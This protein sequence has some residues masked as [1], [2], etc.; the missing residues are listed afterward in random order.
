MGIDYIRAL[1][2]SMLPLSVNAIVA[3]IIVIVG[4][5]LG[6]WLK[7][8]LLVLVRTSCVDK[9]L[10]KFLASFVQYAVIVVAVVAALGT[11]GIQTASLVAVFASVGLALALA[12]KS[13]L[14]DLAGGVVILL[15]R[16]FKIGDHIKSGEHEG[17]VK[18]VGL[19][20]TTIVT[21]KNTQITLPNTQI[22]KTAVEK[23]L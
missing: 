12:L 21:E 7:G 4:W 9:T 3:L 19:F 6:R 5:F 11:I 23:K 8:L 15:F 10:G 18:D 2:Y 16:P 14:S 1:S 13:T 17:E 22:T 20:M